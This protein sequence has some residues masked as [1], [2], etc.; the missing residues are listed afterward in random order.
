LPELIRQSA[1]Y[2]RAWQRHGLPGEYLPLAR[3]DHF[4]IL[5][6]LAQ[7][8]GKILEA[9]GALARQRR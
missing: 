7:P 1:E 5:E 9:L 8:D 3:H 2:A 6:E 4:S